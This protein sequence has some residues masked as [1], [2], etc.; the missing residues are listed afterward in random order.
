MGEASVLGHTRF[1]LK[2]VDAPPSPE[3][4]MNI[5]YQG[6][7]YPIENE[8]IPPYPHPQGFGTFWWDP[9]VVTSFRKNQIHYL[10]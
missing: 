4:L 3:I 5:L 8:T 2:Y 9:E 10:L 6:L 7:L 1:L